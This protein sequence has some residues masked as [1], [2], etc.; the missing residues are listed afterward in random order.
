MYL[1]E[2]IHLIHF[3]IHLLDLLWGGNTFKVVINWMSFRLTLDGYKNQKSHDIWVYINRKFKFTQ[4]LLLE[5][6]KICK[7]YHFFFVCCMVLFI[8]KNNINAK[9]SK[10]LALLTFIVQMD[11]TFPTVFK[12]YRILQKRVMK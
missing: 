3:Y 9:L 6:W 4:N 7:M 10:E 5:R 11:L 1:Y 8:D 2:I 12:L